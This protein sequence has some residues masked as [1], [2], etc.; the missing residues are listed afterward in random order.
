MLLWAASCKGDA[1]VSRE[2]CHVLSTT[3]CARACLNA[4]VVSVWLL[5]G[6]SGQAEEA[7]VTV[8]IAS[9]RAGALR[10]L[11]TWHG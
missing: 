2:F 8:E 6:A 1:A 4:W 11:P 5:W 3:C 7:A 9:R 10:R